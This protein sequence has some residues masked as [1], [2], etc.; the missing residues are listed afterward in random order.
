MLK[1]RLFTA[2]LVLL[3][4]AAGVN[5]DVTLLAQAPRIGPHRAAIAARVA[6]LLSLSTDAVNIKATTTEGLGFV[7]RSEGLVEQATVLVGP[8]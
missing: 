8:A 6:Q 4:A 7:G 1:L 2:G 3:L 5:A